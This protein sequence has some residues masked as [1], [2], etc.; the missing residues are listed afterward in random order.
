MKV[1]LMHPDRDF[2]LEHRLPTNEAALIQ[3][4]ELQTMFAAMAAGDPFVFEVAKRALLL[5]LE[6]PETII[7][8]Q[9]A[10]SDCLEHP[11]VTREL[12]TLAGEALSAEKSVWGGFYR[13]S[14]RHLLSTSL[15]KLEVL[16]DFLRRLRQMAEENAAKF[17]SPAFTRLF[18]ALADELSEPYLNVVQGHLKELAFKGGMLLR[19]QLSAGNK[20][21]N[22]MLRRSDQNW[23]ERVL[24][25]SGYTF[26]IPDRDDNGFRAL[27]ELEDQGA[28][29][30]ANALTQAAQHV[31]SFFLML[32]TEISFYLGCVNLSQKLADKHEPT[33]FPTARPRG[34][35]A[36]SAREL[37]DVSLA[38]TVEQPVV[39]NDVTAEDKSLLIITGANQGGTFLRSVGIAQLMMQCGTFV[40]GESFQANIC[41]GVFTH[42]KR[43][44]D[45]TMESGKLD[46][47]LAKDERDRRSHSS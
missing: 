27:G 39:G 5:S 14:P 6:D 40:A 16:V 25:R 41:D 2:G 20:G 21:T 10:L 9:Q 28:G 13:D 33:C 8:R 11:S 43:E 45:E 17:R 19:A 15:H 36:L 1:L 24:D 35:L 30:V 34:E 37:Y 22:Y 29:A 18:A 31:R 46:E 12:Y 26:T 23:L 38:L 4:L 42:Y 3:D 32:R 47:E 44:E 7:Y